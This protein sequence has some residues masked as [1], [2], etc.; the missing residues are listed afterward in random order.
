MK[1][2][3]ENIVRAI[4]EEP[5]KSGKFFGDISHLKT[6]QVCAVG[7]VIRRE[8]PDYVPDNANPHNICKLLDGSY[9]AAYLKQA[10]KTDNYLSQLSCLFE[11]ACDVLEE[12][13][14]MDLVRDHLVA[15]VETFFPETITIDETILGVKL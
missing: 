15:Y 11:D 4:R 7:A 13:I 10:L 9:N 14:D 8:I 1:I 12:D 5:L 6:C 2:T 3:R